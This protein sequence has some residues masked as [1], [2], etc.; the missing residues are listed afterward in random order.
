M[1]DF[2]ERL[3]DALPVSLIPYLLFA[4]GAALTGLFFALAYILN[5]RE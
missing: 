2:L 3:P 1:Q 4:G 5:R